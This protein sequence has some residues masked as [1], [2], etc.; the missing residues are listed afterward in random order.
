[1]ICDLLP[2]L[3]NLKTTP[4]GTIRIRKNLTLPPNTDV[5]AYC[6]DKIKTS[7]NIVKKGKNW[8]IQVDGIVITVNASSFTIITAHKEKKK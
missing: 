1:M 7:N 6:K 3:P 5:V 4:L 2:N 8:Y